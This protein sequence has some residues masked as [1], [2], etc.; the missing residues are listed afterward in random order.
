MSIGRSCG[1]NTGDTS[2]SCCAQR[3]TVGRLD[4]RFTGPAASAIAEEMDAD[5]SFDAIDGGYTAAI[6]HYLRAEL[7][8][9]NDLPYERIS[10]RVQPWSYAPFEGRPIDVS[11]MLERAM[12]RNPHLLVHIAFGVYDGRRRFPGQW[13]ELRCPQR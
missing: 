3:R 6:N 9:E 7:G 4:S 8:Y 5:P 11:P 2:G 10:E 1:S 12:R 13:P